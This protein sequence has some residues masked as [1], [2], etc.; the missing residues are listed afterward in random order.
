MQKKTREFLINN[1][2]FVLTEYIG[3]YWSLNWKIC[4]PDCFFKDP[5]K[6]QLR[7]LISSYRKWCF[8]DD[9]CVNVF[10]VTSGHYSAETYKEFKLAMLEIVKNPNSYKLK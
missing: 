8:K 1:R 6:K 9:A 10:G 2:R 7:S 4:A 5:I 3:S